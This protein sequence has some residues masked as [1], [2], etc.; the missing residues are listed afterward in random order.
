MTKSLEALI[1]TTKADIAKRKTMPDFGESVD[2][3]IQR[4]NTINETK[5]SFSLENVEALIS[6]LEQAQALATQQG[7]IGCALFDEVTQLHRRIAE[8]EA[9]PLCVNPDAMREVAPLCV[10]LPPVIKVG[11]ADYPMYYAEEVIEAI[12]AAGGTVEVE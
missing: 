11:L 10:K 3:N 4:L 9:R 2:G 6:A 5:A 7:N 1:A 8:L 12:R